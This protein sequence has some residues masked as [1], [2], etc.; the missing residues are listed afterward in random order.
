M[1]AGVPRL[2]A[3]LYPK[4]YVL[5]ASEEGFTKYSST[6]VG[7]P[8]FSSYME[9]TRKAEKSSILVQFHTASVTGTRLNVAVGLGTVRCIHGLTA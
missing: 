2:H 7:R 3:F 9:T 6:C 5:G 4:H 8:K 1:T